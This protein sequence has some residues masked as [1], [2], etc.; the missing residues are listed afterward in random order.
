[1]SMSR[2]DELIA[3]TTTL[4]RRPFGDARH[5]IQRNQI[6]GQNALVHCGR[7]SS[8]KWF[9]RAGYRGFTSAPQDGDLIIFI[10]ATFF[11]QASHPDFRD[12]TGF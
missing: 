2:V 1:M 10:Y 7:G 3:S 8:A 9:L 6:L 5:L 12:C 4:V 11:F